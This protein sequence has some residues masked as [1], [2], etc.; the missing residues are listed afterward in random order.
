[1][2]EEFTRDDVLFTTFKEAILYAVFVIAVTICTIGRRNSSMFY[3]TEALK[4]QFITKEF[5]TENDVGITFEDIKSA[6]DFWYVS[7]SQKKL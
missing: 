1:M 6:T 3:I 5:N 2:A 4:G 7:I